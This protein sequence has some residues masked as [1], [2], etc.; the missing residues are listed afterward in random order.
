MRLRSGQRRRA[1]HADP[2]FAHQRSGGVHG[3]RHYDKDYD[4][5]VFCNCGS[6]STYYAAASD[7]P[8][9]NLKR[10]LCILAWIFTPAAAAM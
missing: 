1:D 8:R 9:E 4:V 2:P 7:D 3:L 10:L 6:Q 5:M